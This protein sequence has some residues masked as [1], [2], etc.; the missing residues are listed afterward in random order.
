M[1]MFL[2]LTYCNALNLEEKY[3]WTDITS[4]WKFSWGHETKVKKNLQRIKKLTPILT[5]GAPS[6]SVARS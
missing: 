2:C 3:E 5:K 1:A 6:F 4:E